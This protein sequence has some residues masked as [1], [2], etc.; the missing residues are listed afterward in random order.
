MDGIARSYHLLRNSFFTAHPIRIKWIS[1]FPKTRNISST[2]VIFSLT[3][4]LALPLHISSRSITFQS[5]QSVHLP[6]FLSKSSLTPSH[7]NRVPSTS[8][9]NLFPA[10]QSARTAS[11]V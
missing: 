6:P 9:K 5:F 4:P 7:P 3:F 11:A 1:Y 2:E 10:P 8:F